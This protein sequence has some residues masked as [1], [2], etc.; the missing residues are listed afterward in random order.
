MVLTSDE[1]E[2][3]F[4][5]NSSG[6]NTKVETSSNK[7]DSDS[8]SASGSDS[9]SSTD[10][11]NSQAHSPRLFKVEDIDDEIEDMDNAQ[12][13]ELL[14]RN[15]TLQA[16]VE[17]LRVSI[18][19][20]PPS[21]KKR[22]SQGLFQAAS[23]DNLF[24]FTRIDR[25]TN[26]KSDL[27]S[28]FILS[29]PSIEDLKQALLN[30]LDKSFI[31]NKLT[32]KVDMNI[33]EEADKEN[34]L[35]ALGID[36]NMSRDTPGNISNV[37]DT[38]DEGSGDISS[39]INKQ[40]TDVSLDIGQLSLNS[41]TPTKKNGASNDATLNKIS[42]ENL[43]DT[44]SS[45]ETPSKK[46]A[47]PNDTTLG[48]KQNLSQDAS[49]NSVDTPSNEKVSP[50]T[51]DPA[52][53]SQDASFISDIGELS[54]NSIA[55]PTPAE[56]KKV[57]PN[58]TNTSSPTTSPKP[59]L[60]TSKVLS[61]LISRSNSL[62]LPQNHIL[63]T[64]EKNVTNRSIVESTSP[65]PNDSFMISAINNRKLEPYS[66][67]ITSENPSPL[68]H[69]P[70]NK[71][72]ELLPSTQSTHFKSFS[73][74]PILS[75]SSATNY[76]SDSK[77][78]SLK[79]NKRKSFTTKKT[80]YDY[81][82]LDDNV[83]GKAAN[84]I[85]N[86]AVNHSNNRNRYSNSSFTS[87]SSKD[88]SSKV[89]EEKNNNP[90][91]DND[92]YN[93][94]TFEID[95]TRNDTLVQLDQDFDMTSHFLK[96][97]QT[98]NT[99]KKGPSSPWSKIRSRTSI[100]PTLTVPKDNHLFG[101][102]NRKSYNIPRTVS[103]VTTTQK[104]D[105]LNKEITSYKI[106]LK[107]FKQFI[108]NLIDKSRETNQDIA[109]LLDIQNLAAINPD[110]STD[111][112]RIFTL[113]TDF[114]NLEKN[115]EEVYKLNEDLYENL[116]NFELQLYNKDEQLRNVNERMDSSMN[117]V[118]NILFSLISDPNT[119]ESSR[120]A[121]TKCIE[122]VT[123]PIDLKLHI[124]GLEL[125]KILESKG[126]SNLQFEGY[127]AEQEEIANQVH[128]IENLMN[129]IEQLK[130][131]LG[132]Q[133]QQRLAIEQDLQREVEESKL[134]K[135][136]FQM[137]S[138]KFNVLC[139]SLSGEK[140]IISNPSSASTE[141]SKNNHELDRVLDEYEEN[142]TRI[143]IDTGYSTT[144]LGK[145]LNNSR[146]ISSDFSGEILDSDKASEYKRVINQLNDELQS[147][148][149]KFQRL[150]EESTKAISSLTKQLRN[151]Q[152]DLDEYTSKERQWNEISA[153]LKV[154]NEKQRVLKT[155]KTRLMTS[156]ENLNKEKQILQERVQ[157]LTDKLVSGNAED[158]SMSRK[159]N[160]VEFQLKELITYDVSIFQK[161]WKSFD[162]IAEDNS[163]K[164]PTKRLNALKKYLKGEHDPNL[165]E[166]ESDGENNARQ[167]HKYI[168]EYFARAVEILV[169]DHVKVLLE[170]SDADV[171]TQNYV[172][173]LFKRIEDL[174]NVN[175]SLSSNPNDT[176][177]DISK[178]KLEEMT[179]RFKA[180]RE[181]RVY[182]N[183][184]ALRRLKELELDNISLREMINQ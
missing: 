166:W 92:H 160:I 141:Q 147:F 153:E 127:L 46:N 41:A 77:L 183:K 171:K 23:I 76:S 25:K 19:N 70:S 26:M 36:K 72:H 86:N 103:D 133:K 181:Q 30:P 117:I 28:D 48:N 65:A 58:A 145:Y 114:Q 151:K 142:I 113:E 44:L 42:E 24:D 63:R 9:G 129:S 179:N 61:D 43:Q 31:N 155:E 96:E 39:P 40:S 94:S 149:E 122:D 11:D 105:E 132:A 35:Q 180:E 173:S 100:N 78:N 169:N 174:E 167:Q 112:N 14:Q 130:S 68:V 1:T 170:R 4:F 45:I 17:S 13:E 150:Q 8:D 49:L 51:N 164:E 34:I 79:N 137:I 109:S 152:Q 104:V 16:S 82:T 66:N 165:F 99:V 162:K 182:E 125:N 6:L 55:T 2:P 60:N 163:F 52:S 131:E 87:R 88:Y 80:S 177:N 83:N 119:D 5:T 21:S 138:Q 102:L 126:N 50:E 7:S 143:R 62:K 146:D 108:Q 57:S 38:Q 121:L 176:T 97:I 95:S 12:I 74:S 115:Y 123:K 73:G 15:T 139:K 54:L 32:E 148:V 135:T 59:A 81:D 53:R 175:D 120:I 75:N 184:Q 154:S 111:R 118:D 98:S 33:I 172:A 128:V 106:Q 64:P 20:P 168:F 18:L 136:N 71:S 110:M 159:M 3:Q 134:I 69:Y 101:S 116:E 37:T 158:K 29:N 89:N 56:R 27:Q 107:F 144:S 84:T 140:E 91:V 22:I 178:I 157:E 161:L 67:S 124:I 47:S 10:S 93:N 85:K 90:K 156:I